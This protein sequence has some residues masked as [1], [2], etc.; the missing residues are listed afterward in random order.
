VTSKG[1][2]ES[3]S[4]EMRTITLH[5]IS[6]MIVKIPVDYER[7]K[8]EGLIEKCELTLQCRSQ[9]LIPEGFKSH[10]AVVRI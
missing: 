6:E 2:I 4:R 8:T 9:Y 3:E 7:N 1:H 10:A 5:K